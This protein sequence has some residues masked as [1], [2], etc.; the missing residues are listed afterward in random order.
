VRF[1]PSAKYIFQNIILRKY[2]LKITLQQIVPQQ[3]QNCFSRSD[4]CHFIFLQEMQFSKTLITTPH[5]KMV[6]NEYFSQ[7]EP[8]LPTAETLPS[9]QIYNTQHNLLSVWECTCTRTAKM[10]A[11]RDSRLVEIASFL[12]V[13]TKFIF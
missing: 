2:F 6:I 12:I 11:R 9:L 7:K 4:Q 10:I 5:V 8:L 1:G 3:L 13:L